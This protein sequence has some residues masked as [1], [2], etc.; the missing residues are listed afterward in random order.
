[1]ICSLCPRKCGAERTE[2]ENSNGFC[3]MPLLPKVARADLHFWEEPVLSGKN[4][5]GTVFFAGCS[6]KC[7]YCQNYKLSHENFGKIF[8]ELEQKGAHN[9][10]LV[11]PTHYAW[12]I[13]KALDIYKPNIPIIY[14]SGGYDSADTLKLLKGYIDIYLLDL[15]YL[16]RDKAKLYSAAE[17]YPDIAK[18][19]I[20]EALR[21]QPECLIKDGIMQKGVIIRHLLLPQGTKE[22]MAVYD[23]VR[24]NAQKAYFSIMSQYTPYGKALNMPPI[25]R[26]V[27]KREYDKVLDY[28]CGYG[29]ENIFIQ[30][31]LSAD[32][33]YIP[34]FNLQGV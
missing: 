10:N 29:G 32:E 18:S 5:S 30:E 26:K 13:I 8:A 17:N 16:S 34:D 27:T 22:A 2:T 11:N 28:I 4:G 7:V 21:Q 12:A 3:K 6:L 23:W 33:K 15:K 25:N 31:L 19:A 20:C 24:L 14:N 9:I 1:M